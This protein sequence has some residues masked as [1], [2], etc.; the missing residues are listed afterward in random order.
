MSVALASC[1][2]G[3]NKTALG[4]TYSMALQYVT[5]A[6]AAVVEA[7]LKARDIPAIVQVLFF[8]ASNAVSSPTRCLG[9]YLISGS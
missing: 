6:V 8:E 3:S 7:P 5:E 9:C 2:P 4:D 1:E